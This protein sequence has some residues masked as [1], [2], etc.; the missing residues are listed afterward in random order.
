ME[1][2]RTNPES[3]ILFFFSFSCRDELFHFNHIDITHRDKRTKKKLKCEIR[4]LASPTLKKTLACVGN[5]TPGVAIHNGQQ[6]QFF[7][8]HGFP[9]DNYT[10]IIIVQAQVL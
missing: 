3:H 6:I 7:Q 4:N 10:D 1:T 9:I 2:S 8:S 5:I